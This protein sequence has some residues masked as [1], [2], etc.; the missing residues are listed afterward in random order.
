MDSTE[1][2]LDLAGIIDIQTELLRVEKE[3]DNTEKK[4]GENIRQT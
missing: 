4:H 1:I 3:I 2:C